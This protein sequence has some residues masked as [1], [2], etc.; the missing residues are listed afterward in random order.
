[1]VALRYT[2]NVVL[3]SELVQLLDGRHLTVMM[4][5]RGPT[6]K[7][8]CTAYTPVGYNDCL[9][10]PY[11]QKFNIHPELELG[12]RSFRMVHLYGNSM[13]TF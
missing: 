5:H 9:I 8:V 7:V 12:A 1:M 2:F 6:S 4:V 3:A 10:K 13:L 11:Y